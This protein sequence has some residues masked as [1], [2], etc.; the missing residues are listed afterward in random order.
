MIHDILG[1]IL[2]K[3]IPL[4]VELGHFKF[5]CQKMPCY[6]LFFAMQLLMAQQYPGDPPAA[7]LPPSAVISKALIP[8]DMRNAYEIAP[9][10]TSLKVCTHLVSDIV[11]N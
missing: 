5:S 4:K 7:P 1:K 6:I 11:F 2:C 8:Y 9:E 3:L 10:P